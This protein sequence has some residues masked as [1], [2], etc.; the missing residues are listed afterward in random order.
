MEGETKPPHELLL[1]QLILSA[2]VIGLVGHATYESFY[3]IPKYIFEFQRGKHYFRLAGKTRIVI[4]EFRLSPTVLFLL[5]VSSAYF[6]V[7]LLLYCT[8]KIIKEPILNGT[9]LI[10]M[11]DVVFCFLMFACSIAAVAYPGE[12][13]TGSR[14]TEIIIA[15]GVSMFCCVSSGVGVYYSYRVYKGL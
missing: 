4:N 5:T 15:S 9:I 1:A 13:A 11:Q 10:L 7:N 8:N 6:F 14:E 3:E 2:V 12:R